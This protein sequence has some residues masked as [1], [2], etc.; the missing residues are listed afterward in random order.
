M[1]AQRFELPRRRTHARIAIAL[2]AT[3]LLAACAGTPPTTELAVARSAVQDASRDGAAQHAP[4]QFAL[5]Q[6]KL[7]RAETANRSDD[8]TSARRLATEAEADAHVA[9]ATARAVQAQTALGT[10][11]QGNTTLQQQLEKQPATP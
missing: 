11:Q 9:G 7:A 4:A 5:A 2:G 3:I 10:I 1:S 6:D 8:F